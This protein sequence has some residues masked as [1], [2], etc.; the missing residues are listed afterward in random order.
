MIAR[1]DWSAYPLVYASQG[2][3]RAGAG[4]AEARTSTSLVSRRIV[5]EKRMQKNMEARG[6]CR[7]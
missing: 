2:R 3:W 7:R 5:Y 6:T 4:W 1:V